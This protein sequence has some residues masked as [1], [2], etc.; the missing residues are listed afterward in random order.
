VLCVYEPCELA[1]LRYVWR[2]GCWIIVEFEKC[3]C[4]RRWAHL[5]S[6]SQFLVLD[7]SGRCHIH[8]LMARAHVEPREPTCDLSCGGIVTAHK[9]L[10]WT[11]RME[12]LHQIN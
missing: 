4:Q 10:C 6:A 1:V 2:R 12:K 8:S 9:K 3:Q 7:S 11:R 5:Y